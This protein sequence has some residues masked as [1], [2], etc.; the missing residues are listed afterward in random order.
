M[1]YEENERIIYRLA[2][3]FAHDPD[4][5]EEYVSIGNLAYCRAVKYYDGRVKFSTFLYRVVLNSFIE[6]KRKQETQ[7]WYTVLRAEI[8]VETIGTVRHDPEQIFMFSQEFDFLSD[9]ARNIAFTLIEVPTLVFACTEGTSH[10]SLRQAARKVLIGE[11]YS[12]AQISS[13]YFEIQA[14]LGEK[15]EDQDLGSHQDLP[16]PE[17]PEENYCGQPYRPEPSMAR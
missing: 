14:W 15:N 4:Q 13:A 2:H 12:N 5:F 16:M 6:E 3:Q 17:T 11:G 10:R 1:I 8:E 7:K 9:N